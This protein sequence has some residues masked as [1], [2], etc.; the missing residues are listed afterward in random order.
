MHS[1]S[2]LARVV[3]VMAPLLWACSP[4]YPKCETDANCK[5][6]NEVCVQGQCKECATDTNCKAGFVC[7]Q[8]KCVPKPAAAPTPAPEAAATG[9]KSCSS[10]NDCGEKQLCLRN[11]CV[12]ITPDMAECGSARVHFDFNSVDFK[13]EDK[14]TL[15]R[16]AKCARASAKLHVTIEGNADERGTEEYN[17]QLSQRRA[18]A[19]AK[20]LENLGASREQL[21][22][23]GYG[24]EQPECKEHDEAC[25][26]KNRRAGLK[27]SAQ[28]KKK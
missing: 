22:T 10:D 16:M 15:D 2:L 19:V 1:S 4:T 26:A 11:V 21:D 12:D 23:I 6:H 28:P 9:P 7:E 20:Y 17:L 13:P 27:P 8:N 25:W 18:A 24:E 5:D 3:V 14:G